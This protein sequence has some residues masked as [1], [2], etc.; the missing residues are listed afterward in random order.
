MK[1]ITKITFV[2]AFVA[3]AGYGVYTNRTVDTMSVLSL[4]NID[5]LASFNGYEPG[6]ECSGCIIN[7]LYVCKVFGD[8]GGCIGDPYIHQA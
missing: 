7:S 4:A 8:W 5:A 3:I 1:K 2:A 6:N